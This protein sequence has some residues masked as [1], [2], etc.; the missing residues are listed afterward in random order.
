MDEARFGVEAERLRE[1][2]RGLET[3]A[4]IPYRKQNF[5]DYHIPTMEL[6]EGMETPGQTGFALHSRKN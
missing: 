5:G 1:R 2:M 6:R 4:P 3:E